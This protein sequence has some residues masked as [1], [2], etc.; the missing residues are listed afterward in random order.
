M[1]EPLSHIGHKRRRELMNAAKVV[2]L[3]DDGARTVD[4]QRISRAV[5]ANHKSI[6]ESPPVWAT[7]RAELDVRRRKLIDAVQ[8]FAS[9]RTASELQQEL[10]IARRYGAVLALESINLILRRRLI[11]N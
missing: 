11:A 8:P 7:L 4:R 2:I 1:A 5:P 6:V 3:D 9:D 10:A